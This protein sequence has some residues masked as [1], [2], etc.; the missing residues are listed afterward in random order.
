MVCAGRVEKW[1]DISAE[2]TESRECRGCIMHASRG[3]VIGD[4]LTEAFKLHVG[5]MR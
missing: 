5:G 2:A 4:T 1:K 3:S